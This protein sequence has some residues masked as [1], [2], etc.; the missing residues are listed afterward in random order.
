MAQLRQSRGR[1]SDQSGSNRVGAVGLETRSNYNFGQ[2]AAEV[3]AFCGRRGPLP[4]SQSESWSAARS[5]LHPQARMLHRLSERYPSMLLLRQSDSILLRLT[6][7]SRRSLEPLGAL[8]C[9]S[10]LCSPLRPGLG[11][12]PRLGGGGFPGP[13]AESP[14]L[15]AGP[16]S[17]AA[18]ASNAKLHHLIPPS[19]PS[20]EPGP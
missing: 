10:P 9:A 11:G 5:A 7:R 1:I 17:S 16:E 6:G 13:P 14:K 2:G 19:Q 4:Q 3:E 20:T 12:G 15:A 18:N 8:G